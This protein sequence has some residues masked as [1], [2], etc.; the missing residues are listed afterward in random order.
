MCE[1]IYGWRAA[2][3]AAIVRS[4]RGEKEASSKIN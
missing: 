4:K 3:V 2:A 1:D